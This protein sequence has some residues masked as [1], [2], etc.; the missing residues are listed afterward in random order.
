MAA[1]NPSTN[2]IMET[3]GWSR[4]N[5]N[6]S[7]CKAMISGL[8]SCGTSLYGFIPDS[9]IRTE[10]AKLLIGLRL[11]FS[12]SLNTKLMSE[13]TWFPPDTA[14]ESAKKLSFPPV[15][16]EATRKIFPRKKRHR[17]L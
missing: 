16:I 17:T 2:P 9:F 12:G 11:G 8:T 4:G 5:P 6:A 10:P 1:L 7:A 14:P 3:V 15:H 13:I